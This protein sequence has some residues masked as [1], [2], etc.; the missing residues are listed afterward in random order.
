MIIY[1]YLFLNYKL[2]KE[3]KQVLTINFRY[4]DL[5]AWVWAED[6]QFLDQIDTLVPATIQSSVATLLC[7]MIV[8]G[9]FMSNLFTVVVATL[10]IISICIGSF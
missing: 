6:A 5:E 7:M 9:I 10:S 8:C 3:L 4:S 1:N 2:N